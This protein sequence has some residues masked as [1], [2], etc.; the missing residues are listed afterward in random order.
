MSSKELDCSYRRVTHLKFHS[1]IL[2]VLYPWHTV[3][4]LPFSS[5]PRKESPIQFTCV[6]NL[7][8][9]TSKVMEKGSKPTTNKGLNWDSSPKS[10]KTMLGTADQLRLLIFQGSETWAWVNYS[11]IYSLC[12]EQGFALLKFF[13]FLLV[14]IHFQ[15]EPSFSSCQVLHLNTQR[16]FLLLNAWECTGI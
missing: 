2:G 5:V 15:L 10:P 9:S 12:A 14:L 6:I 16:L 11:V 1:G 3:C 7:H 8:T 4:C 13:L